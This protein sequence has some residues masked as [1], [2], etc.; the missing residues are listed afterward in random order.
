MRKIISICLVVCLCLQLVGC[1]QETGEEQN[2]SG[3]KNEK[4]EEMMSSEEAFERAEKIVKKMTLD[5]KLG[6]L[7]IIDL[8]KL[9]KN[10]KPVTKMTDK[11]RRFIEKYKV[12]GVVLD[13]DNICETEQVKKLTG[14]LADCLEIPMYVATEEE[15]GG[16][17]SI[18]GKKK[19]I[20]STGYLSPWE[21]G[22]NMTQ[23]QIRDTGKVIGQ[24]L[25]NLGFNLNF[26][27][28]AD[29][30]EV[31]SAEDAEEA[32]L[33]AYTAFSEKEM[34]MEQFYNVISKGGKKKKLVLDQKALDKYVQKGADKLLKEYTEENYIERCFGDDEDKVRVSV[35]AMVD[36]MHMG[37]VATVLKTFPGI[38]SAV[39]YHKLVQGE[40]DTG[41][42]RLRRVNFAPYAAGIKAGTDVIMVGHVALT[43]VDKDTPASMSKVI[44]SELLR[45]EMD[46]EGVVMTEAM[47]LPVITNE[48]TTE[49]AVLRSLVSG[50]SLI[51]NPEDLQEAI[52]AVKRALMFQEID[53][54]RINQSVLRVIQNKLMRGVISDT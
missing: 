27:P 42:S 20:F 16:E 29:V 25:A 14:E 36:G 11:I 19:D 1:S 18:A 6:Q 4:K 30:F 31:G 23:D 47:D 53:E 26:A 48:Y 40:I 5:E 45:D 38:A 28:T 2:V 8:D 39:R 12:A 46:F 54:K 13:E 50:A 3:Q 21:M 15:G 24:E 32:S 10:G 7:F 43:K 37:K 34:S 22:K 51:Y 49:Q 52:F 33:S 44:M 17:H 35:S 41:V 9:S